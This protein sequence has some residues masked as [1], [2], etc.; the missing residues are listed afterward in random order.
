MLAERT[1]T[2]ELRMSMDEGQQ[3]MTSAQNVLRHY[4]VQQ[5]QKTLD[6]IAFMGVAA[7]LYTPRIGA[8]MMRKNAEK[9][10]TPP[11]MQ[12]SVNSGDTFFNGVVMEPAPH[13]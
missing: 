6:W 8:Y 13:G 9:H 3:F 11:S 2:P 12:P 4:S 5:T 7:G 1:E 10:Q